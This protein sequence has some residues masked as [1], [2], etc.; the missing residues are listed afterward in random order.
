MTLQNRVDPWGKLNA[1]PSKSATLMGNRGGK[2]HNADKQIIKQFSTQS[3][4]NCLT[5]FGN[6]K[7][8]VFGQSYSELFFLDEA[9]ALAAG[10]RPCGECQNQRYKQFKN[11]WIHANNTG[12]SLPVKEMDKKIHH[13]RLTADKNKKTFQ[14]KISDL[15]MGT[16]FEHDS[17]AIVIFK[18]NHYLVWSFDG[19]QQEVE[20]PNDLIVNVLTPESFVKAF[21]EGFIPR[22]HHSASLK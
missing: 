4:I 16:F 20:L 14:A 5:T 18:D 7:R 15:P 13:D 10:H 6:V 8:E 9:T 12:I 19:Y 21:D 2:L 11:A 17:K 3:W 22:F 1:H